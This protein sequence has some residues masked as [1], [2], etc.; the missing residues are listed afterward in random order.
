[1]EQMSV[2]FYWY[3]VTFDTFDYNSRIRGVKAIKNKRKYR[4]MKKDLVA[5][6]LINK[7]QKLNDYN[8][9]YTKET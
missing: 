6:Y 4:I 5:L 1:M 8:Y 7:K 2:L 9:E 3:T